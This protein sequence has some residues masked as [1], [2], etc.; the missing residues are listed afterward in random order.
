MNHSPICDKCGREIEWRIHQHKS[1]NTRWIS[2]DKITKKRHHQSCHNGIPKFKT[3]DILIAFWLKSV[4]LYKITY[5]N[6]NN[7]EYNMIDQYSPEK[8]KTIDFITAERFCK[9]LDKLYGL[10]YN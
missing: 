4:G 1:P 5:V 2:Y 7:L 8:I 10:L 6:L 9:K 3:Y